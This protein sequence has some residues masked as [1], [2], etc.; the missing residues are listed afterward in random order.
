MLSRLFLVDTSAWIFALR[1]KF[2]PSIKDRIDQLL[3]DYVVV[4][5][6]MIKL[7]L[8]GGVK[9]EKEFRRLK[10]RLNALDEIEVDISVWEIAYQTAFELRQKGI[11]VPYTDILTAASALKSKAILVHADKHFD[12]MARY[13]D[14]EVESFVQEVRQ[15][16]Y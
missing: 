12:L 14:L 2:I 5:N 6:G 15:Y 1:K 7:E 3:K 9:T 11:T 13:I 16:N 8:L 10:S 4:T